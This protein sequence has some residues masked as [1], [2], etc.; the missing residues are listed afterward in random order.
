MIFK[1]KKQ[2]EKHT[3]IN[4]TDGLFSL[5]KGMLSRAELNFEKYLKNFRF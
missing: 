3:L 4:G 1:L 5:N 2:R